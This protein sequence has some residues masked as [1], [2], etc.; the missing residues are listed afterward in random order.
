MVILATSAESVA[1]TVGLG[2]AGFVGLP[3]IVCLAFIF[4]SKR[5]DRR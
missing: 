5:L 3:L 4:I 2:F 1:I